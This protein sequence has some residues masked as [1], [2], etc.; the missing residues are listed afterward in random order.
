MKEDGCKGGII[1]GLC[2][3]GIIMIRK[4]I[5]PSIKIPLN[6]T[7][8][9]SNSFLSGKP[10]LLTGNEF[11]IG[12]CAHMETHMTVFF[13][14]SF[15]L[16][17]FSCSFL[18]RPFQQPPSGLPPSPL[19]PFL[20]STSTLSSPNSHPPVVGQCFTPQL[21]RDPRR[22]RFS[23]TSCTPEWRMPPSHRS[24]IYCPRVDG[25]R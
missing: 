2:K 10:S 19:L 18:L 25:F 12:Y 7:L 9:V 22:W 4:S 6:Q 16:F 5:R 1:L 15:F 3:G 14:F 20:P 23:S 13:F 8:E 24:L 17:S 21:E 11:L